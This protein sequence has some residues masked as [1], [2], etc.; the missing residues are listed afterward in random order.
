MRY[1]FNETSVSVCIHS[2][3]QHSVKVLEKKWWKETEEKKNKNTP[4]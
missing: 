1:K 3:F 4:E 2:M